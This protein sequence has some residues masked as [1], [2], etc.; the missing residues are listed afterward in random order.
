[1]RQRVWEVVKRRQVAVCAVVFVLCGTSV[2]MAGGSGAATGKKY[3]ACVTEVY[4]TIN[5]TTARKGC[6]DGQRIISFNARGQRGLRGRQGLAGPAGEPGAAGAKGDAGAAGAAGAKGDTG[7]TGAVGPQGETGEQGETRRAGR[8]RGRRARPGAGRAGRGW[9]HGSGG[10]RRD[11]PD[12]RA[13][14][15]APGPPGTAGDRGPIGPTGNTGAQGPVGP[16]GPAGPAGPTGPAGGALVVR[17]GTGAA[18]G[19]VVSPRPARTSPSSRPPGT[20]SRSSGRAVSTRAQIYYT[21]PC[22]GARHGLPEQRQRRQ[23]ARRVHQP[24]SGWCSRAS[25]EQP[26]RA[27][28]RGA[29]DLGLGAG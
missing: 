26:R 12:R 19:R 14:T 16:A 9:R 28:D 18:L 13:S 7:A 1:M 4:R 27:G 22:G 3:Y 5:L 11:R 20:S 2:A 29:T 10:A 24:A 6:P 25:L 21:G 23:R 17:D 8:D 15:G